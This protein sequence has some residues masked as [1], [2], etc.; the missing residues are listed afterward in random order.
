MSLLSHLQNTAFSKYG[1]KSYAEKI[2]RELFDGFIS[3][4]EELLSTD[5]EIVVLPT[6]IWRF[7]LHPTFYVFYFKKHWIFICFKRKKVKYFI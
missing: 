4:N 1:D 2:R 6:P 7:L 5:K 3:E